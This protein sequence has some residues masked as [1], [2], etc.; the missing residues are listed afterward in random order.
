MYLCHTMKAVTDTIINAHVD[1]SAFQGVIHPVTVIEPQLR[2]GFDNDWMVIVFC[3]VVAALAWIRVAFPRK[4][5]QIINTFLYNRFV[6]QAMR[7]ELV[8]SHGSSIALTISFILIAGLFLMQLHN[9]EFLGFHLFAD[10]GFVLYIKLCL[11]LTAIYA[12]KV[13]LMQ[14]LQFLVRNDSGLQ[15][16]IFNTFLINKVL[17]MLLLPMVIGIAYMPSVAAPVLFYTG[18]T[19]I[20]ITYI[21]RVFRGFVAAITNN[22]SNFYLLLYLCTLEILPLIVIFLL[23]NRGI[24]TLN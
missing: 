10:T 17:G 23:F 8:L 15:E 12:V 5:K 4:H 2:N 20:G 19:L 7:E 6:R 22:V 18:L 9:W 16:Y 21:Y 13:L 24:G 11:L 3:L 14:F 1:V